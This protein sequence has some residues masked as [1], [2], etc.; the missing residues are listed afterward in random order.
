MLQQP[1]LCY[2]YKMEKSAKTLPYKLF[3]ETFE[4]VINSKKDEEMLKH[5]D[6]TLDARHVKSG[7]FGP[8]ELSWPVVSSTNLSSYKIVY[9]L[10][11][12]SGAT[13]N[14]YRGKDA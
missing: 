1:L 10:I 9:L 3:N 8:H 2:L 14:A 4:I 13:N 6:P 5:F 11:H 12:I 7:Y